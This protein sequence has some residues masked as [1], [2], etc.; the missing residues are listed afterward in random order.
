M[1]T[2]ILLFISANLFANTSLQN[3][4]QNL[5]SHLIDFKKCDLN[6][7][8]PDYS[9]EAIDYFYFSSPLNTNTFLF[10]FKNEV[11]IPFVFEDTPSFSLSSYGRNVE[12]EKTYVS[13][14]LDNWN[15]SEL[16]DFDNLLSLILHENFHYFG[17]KNI[18]EQG[19][20]DRGD[21]YPYKLEPRL[22][23]AMVIYHLSQAL[24]KPSELDKHFSHAKYWNEKHKNEFYDDYI[25]SGD[26]DLREGSATY[27]ELYSL[28]LI[29]NNCEFNQDSF[30]ELFFNSDEGDSHIT[31]FYHYTEF[32]KEGQSYIGGMLAYMLDKVYFNEAFEL[33]K[34]AS[35]AVHPI[36]A[37]V[38]DSLVQESEMLS[39]IIETIS[40]EIENMNKQAKRIVDE[41]EEKRKLGYSLISF[42]LEEIPNQGSFR[43]R[44]F[45]NTS[46]SLFGFY[47]V[48][49][50]L[51]ATY[52]SETTKMIVNG[53]NVYESSKNACGE[54]QYTMWVKDLK[55]NDIIDYQ[56]DEITINSQSF[57]IKNNIICVK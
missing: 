39:E 28:I 51:R 3:Y 10:D 47:Q 32:D 41:Y 57:E 43:L 8:W 29:Q 52:E 1:K 42:N 18:H 17:Q 40:P 14:R 11:N 20:T 2:L 35:D 54:Q 34:L 37:L 23:R 13:Y 6:E 26:L 44:N 38:K 46:E 27:A 22:Y 7:I 16:K 21:S 30:N 49:E 33:F 55:I 9:W 12:A 53:L 15:G 50:S 36:E 31:K 19:F 56:S 25:S 4:Y 45:I 48:M 24:K 5:T